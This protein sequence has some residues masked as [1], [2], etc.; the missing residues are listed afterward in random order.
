[1]PTPDT[2][3]TT[4]ATTAG[5]LPWPRLLAFCAVLTLAGTVLLQATGR[6]VGFLSL[7]VV[8]LTM[9]AGLLLLVSGGRGRI[10][11]GAVLIGV[12]SLLNNIHAGLFLAAVTAPAGDPVTFLTCLTTWIGSLLAIPLAVVTFRFPEGAGPAVLRRAVALVLAV[13]TAVAAVLFVT[14][15][16][17]PARPGDLQVTR[18]RE[19]WGLL[20]DQAGRSFAPARLTAA[21]GP[22]TIAVTN[23]DPLVGV[24]FLIP[25]LGV[26]QEVAPGTTARV[27][28]DAPA[29]SYTLLDDTFLVESSLVVG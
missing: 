16:D 13:A 15:A 3:T 22:V 25:E 26:R 14:A 19:G 23:T 29:G 6:F 5:R 8:D 18:E 7:V 27:T 21:P 9:L 12:F 20:T 10:R 1:M 24:R 28:F 11:S 2:R 17:D 4:P